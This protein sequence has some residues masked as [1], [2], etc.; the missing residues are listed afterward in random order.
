M[1]KKN[2]IISIFKPIKN[3]LIQTHRSFFSEEREQIPY[4]VC[5][6][7]GGIAGLSAAIRLKQLTKVKGK[8]VSI[9]VLEKGSEIG[10]HVL[11]GNIFDPNYLKELFS[12]IDWLNP[13]SPFSQPVVHDEFKI[14]L[15]KQIKSINIPHF[16]LPNEINNKGNYVISL[17]SL[18]KWLAEKAVELEVDIFTGFSVDKLRFDE[19]NEH[20]CGVIVKDTG[21]DKSGKKKDGFQSG[22]EIIS[23]ITILAEGARGSLSQK[24]IQH[25]QL[26]KNCYPQTYGL[27]IK[28]IWEV[29]KKYVSPGYVLHTVG[30]PTFNKAYAG[31]FLYTARDIQNESNL[32]LRDKDN[33][34][35]ARYI[36]AG[37]IVG[38][39]YKNPYL[40]PYEEFQMW[41]GSDEI[42]AILSNA[43][44][45]KY[46]ARVINEG[47]FNSIPK[48]TFPGGM[49]IGCS[50]GFVN[51][52]KIK[53]S[54]NAMK[55]GMIAAE[56]IMDAIS[57]GNLDFGKEITNYSKAMMNSKVVQELKQSRNFRLGFSEGLLSGLIHGAVVSITKGKEPWTFKSDETDSKSTKIAEEYK[58]IEYPKHDGKISF[59]ILESVSRSGT[60]HDHDQPSHLKI[61]KDLKNSPIE[62]LNT[63]AGIEGFFIRKILSGESI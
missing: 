37:Y 47:G 41:K 25:F 24:A 35:S 55:S 6:V 12:D 21:I 62:S 4:D 49:L 52:M 51:V 11:S 32:I 10:S 23:P 50:A 61:K 53:G 39:D 27:G 59:D 45:I 60:H 56:E 57:Q 36:H 28:E 54:N 2:K 29:D 44:V 22:A 18:C 63:Y 16:L 30:Y 40:N 9:C 15:N 42:K 14:L 31:G 1:F 48:L 20:V 46:G 5:I 17:G 38:L 33:N 58:K 26:D 34:P 7:G 3:K 8:P 19:K 43:K 13:P